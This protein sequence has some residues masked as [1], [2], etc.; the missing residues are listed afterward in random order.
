MAEIKIS[1]NIPNLR[2]E[3]EQI[4]SELTNMGDVVSNIP[5]LITSSN[6]LR[7]NEYLLKLDQKKTDLISLYAQYSS[8]METMLSSLFEI[9]HELTG[10]LQEQSSML[11][12]SKPKS[13][14][15]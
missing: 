9:Q 5:E 1:T 7:S 14:P 8:S 4:Q 13:K 6:L 12:Y 3:I 2:K 10:I 15:E 11:T